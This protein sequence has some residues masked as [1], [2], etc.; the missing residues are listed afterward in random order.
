MDLFIIVTHKKL[1]SDKG[2]PLSPYLFLI[3]MT[4]IFNDVQQKDAEEM[5]RYHAQNTI[6]DEVIYADGTIVLSMNT[7]A[8]NG[9]VEKIERHGRR[10]ITQ[11]VKSLQTSQAL[12]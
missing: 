7:R 5:F 1:G 9:Y 8:M 2:C 4:V 3:G 6:F 11:N 10:F 12:L